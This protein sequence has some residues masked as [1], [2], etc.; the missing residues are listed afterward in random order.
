MTL[1]VSPNAISLSQVSVELLYMGPPQ[2]PMIS[3]N[4]AQVRA[5]FGKSSGAISLSDGW[6]KSTS[7][8]KPIVTVTNGN[9]FI[10]FDWPANAGVTFW[11][12]LAGASV[13]S[14]T[15]NY[16]QITGLGSNV[17]KTFTV[18][19]TKSGMTNSATSTSV[20]GTTHTLYAGPSFSSPIIT[21]STIAFRWSNVS[22]ASGY[23]VSTDNAT[24]GDPNGTLAHTLSSLNSNQTYTLYVRSLNA[25]SDAGAS[26][27]NSQNTTYSLPVVTATLHTTDITYTWPADI[28]GNTAQYSHNNSTW[29]NVSSSLTYVR[30]TSAATSYTTYFRWVNGLNV[31]T[32]VTSGPNTTHSVIAGPVFTTPTIS[33]NGIIFT[34][35]SVAGV[36]SYQ[37]STDNASWVSTNNG[38]ASHNLTGLNMNQTYQLYVRAL[39]AD[40][41]AG[42]STYDARTT[43]FTA[44]T[45]TVAVD[46]WSQITYTWINP[47]NNSPQYS[48]NNSTWITPVGSTTSWQRTGLSASSPYTSYFRWQNGL[49]ISSSIASGPVSTASLP[50]LGTPAFTAATGSAGR[51]SFTWGAIANAT[52]YDVT[53]NGATT[54]QTSTTFAVMSGVSAG[55]YSLSVV[56]KAV[57]FT[58][59]NAG[60]SSNVT[61]T[62]PKLETPAFTN[63]TGG[64]AA[65]SFTWGAIA[66]AT[67]YDVTFNGTTTNQAGVTFIRGSGV[68]VG[69]YTLTV[70]AK[71]TGYINSDAR[72]STTVTVTVYA[73]I[74]IT[75]NAAVSSG[76]LAEISTIHYYSFT[77]VTAITYSIALNSANFDAYVEL[78]DSTNTAQQTFNDDGGGNNNS[79]ATYLCLA[80]TTYIIRVH[81][82]NFGGSGAYTLALTATLPV[83]GTPVYSIASGGI[84]AVSFEWS[85]ISGATSY[86]VTFNGS[87]TN[88]AG[89]SFSRTS[90]AAGTY[91]LTV[92]AKAVGYTNSSNG[93]S[94]NVIATA[95]VTPSN[96]TFGFSNVTSSGFRIS[97]SA[98]NALNYYLYTYPDYL[99]VGNNTTG[100]FDITGKDPSTT[101]QYVAFTQSSTGQTSAWSPVASQATSA[102]ALA[103]PGQVTLTVSNVTSTTARITATTNSGGAVDTYYLFRTINGTNTFV[104]SASN[105]IFD[106]TDMSPS[107]LYGPY[108]SYAGNTTNI[109]E[110][111]SYEVYVQTTAAA[112]VAPS[113]PTLTV[114]NILATQFDIQMTATNANNYL[115]FEYVAGTWT[116]RSSSAN[117]AFNISGKTANTQYYFYGVASNSGGNSSSSAMLTVNT[118]AAAATFTPISTSASGITNSNWYTYSYTAPVTRQYTITATGFDSQVSFDGFATQVDS[119]NQPGN[120]EQVGKNWTAD[121]QVTIYVRAFSTGGGTLSF[122]IT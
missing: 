78:Y 70:I 98:T 60:L 94:S 41:V 22:G 118:I 16:L 114:S 15:N 31:T 121:Q 3:L 32:V 66:G 56:A 120:G 63:A 99:L 59:S 75:V 23:Q 28:A 116:Y 25:Y 9:G 113:A 81:A 62:M 110:Y 72:V 58:N 85:S 18:Y 73:P 36:S 35:T 109:S 101:Y 97:L 100:I 34:W 74:A 95:V 83:L 119:D 91:N 19:A 96:P 24:W 7:L 21:T 103:R 86:D 5:L 4:D 105:G 67:S 108:I 71:A 55:T 79:L 102:P 42:G 90:V 37:V 17:S 76:T 40:N 122:S 43:T 77:T 14:T 65:V 51:V 8:V 13:V 45:I 1:P 92:V 10:Y 38:L 2:N 64:S 54:N 82:Y 33:N 112:P 27:T 48:I 53:F 93:V 104:R 47:A 106:L 46:S 107:T 117:G 49:N 89:T 68:A 30:G 26:T 39:N 87:T 12:S 84:N 115:L 11:Y 20:T 52:S 6:G 50:K 80:N 44:P 29:T 111:W 61:V 57:D 88:Q 69:S